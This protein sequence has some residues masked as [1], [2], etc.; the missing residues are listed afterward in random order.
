[1]V[2]DK[3]VQLHT[4][5][6]DALLRTYIQICEQ[7]NISSVFVGDLGVGVGLLHRINRTRE[8]VR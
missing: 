7:H 8:W 3:F 5:V 6:R 2:A 4:Y 1:M